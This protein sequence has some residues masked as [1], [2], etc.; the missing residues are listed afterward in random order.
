[1]Y[2]SISDESEKGHPYF[3][4]NTSPKRFAEQMKFLYDNYYEDATTVAGKTYYYKVVAKDMGGYELASAVVKYV[5]EQGGGG[6][7]P[8]PKAEF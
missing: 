4:I 8:K 1:M 6:G 2:H 3:W 7:A 5:A